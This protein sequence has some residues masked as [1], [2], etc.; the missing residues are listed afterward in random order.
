MNEAVKWHVVALRPKSIDAVPQNSSATNASSQTPYTAR[1]AMDYRLAN[2]HHRPLIYVPFYDRLIV[3]NERGDDIERQSTYGTQALLE[4]VYVNL[5]TNQ[6]FLSS[7]IPAAAPISVPRLGRTFLRN[8]DP[9]VD[10]LQ[11]F[12]API[13]DI[14]LQFPANETRHLMG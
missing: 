9:A 2:L 3:P 10:A 8:F 7:F 6:G 14:H 13:I 1:D 11:S 4:L 12:P 5:L